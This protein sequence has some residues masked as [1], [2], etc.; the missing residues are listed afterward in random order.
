M[1]DPGEVWEGQLLE[2]YAKEII[3][4]PSR[5]NP[6]TELWR[7]KEYSIVLYVPTMVKRVFNDHEDAKLFAESKAGHAKAINSQLEGGGGS[8]EL[9]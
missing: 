6:I 8:N 1:S 3:G 7:F 2:R 4:Y 5:E 9:L